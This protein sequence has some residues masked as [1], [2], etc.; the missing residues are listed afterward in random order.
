[1][2]VFLGTD[3]EHS[4]PLFLYLIQNYNL[5]LHFCKIA[6]LSF[7]HSCLPIGSLAYLGLDGFQN[8]ERYQRGYFH[9]IRIDRIQYLMPLCPKIYWIFPNPA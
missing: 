8:I 1:M 3:G 7:F 6:L 2:S 4:L 9:L 5:S